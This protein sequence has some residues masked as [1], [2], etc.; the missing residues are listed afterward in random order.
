MSTIRNVTILHDINGLRVYRNGLLMES[1]A[2]EALPDNANPLKRRLFMKW[3]DESV[4]GAK[5][6]SDSQQQGAV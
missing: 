6:Q 1:I 2:S 5:T 4:L 3:S